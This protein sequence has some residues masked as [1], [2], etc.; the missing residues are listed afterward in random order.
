FSFN[1]LL[2]DHSWNTTKFNNVPNGLWND[3][4]N[5]R[6]FF[7]DLRQELGYKNWEDWYNV[8]S[9][10]IIQKGGIGIL[11]YYYNGSPSKAL[12]TVYPEYPW[13]LW[14]FD[15]LPRG[16]WNDMNNQRSFFDCLGQE[17][18]YT[19]WVNWYNI[20]YKEIIQ[21]GGIGILSHYNDSLSKA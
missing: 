8:S 16:F 7:D 1:H 21:K 20:P 12:A 2:K 18:G 15:T 4:N 10:E 13:K 6:S 17:L 3:M 11:N 14:K 9:K 19:N 5:Q